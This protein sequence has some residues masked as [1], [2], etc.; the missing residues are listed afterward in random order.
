[1]SEDWAHATIHEDTAELVDSVKP[2]WMARSSFVDGAVWMFYGHLGHGRARL[3]PTEKRAIMRLKETGV[4]V[5]QLADA[6]GVSRG[7]IENVQKKMGEGGH[8]TYEE[9]SE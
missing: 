9:R 8:R 6:F 1:M 7:K 5:Q 3:S 4:G 2:D